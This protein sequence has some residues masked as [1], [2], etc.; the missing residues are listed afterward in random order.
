MRRYRIGG[1]SFVRQGSCSGSPRS[2]RSWRFP[3]ACGGAVSVVALWSPHDHLLSVIAPIGLAVTKR[4]ALV[5]DLD[6]LGPLFPGSFTLAD[7]VRDG[8]T[9]EQLSPSDRS[10]AI[11]ANGGVSVPEAAKV[12]AALVERWPNVV[13]RCSPAQPAPPAAV[14]L[15]PLLPAP[16]GS[17]PTPRTV[18]QR[19]GFHTE[20]PE[21]SLVLPRPRRSTIEALMGLRRMPKRSAWLH[22][23]GRVWSAG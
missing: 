22:Q 7:L 1:T 17:P 23:L 13:L 5:I 21:E 15:I 16:F 14:S 9:D 4:S 11:L 3:P 10:I 8:P 6:P 2:I 20:A 18:Y 12:V 19:T